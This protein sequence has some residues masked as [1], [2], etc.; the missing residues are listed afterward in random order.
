MYLPIPTCGTTQLH[1]VY[2]NNQGVPALWALTAA[3]VN[4]VFPNISCSVDTIERVLIREAP[5]CSLSITIDTEFVDT[6]RHS[7]YCI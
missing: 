4:D 5:H 1:A 2:M 7:L 3:N 6:T